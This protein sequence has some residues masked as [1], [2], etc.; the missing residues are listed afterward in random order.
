MS[1]PFVYR[2]SPLTLPDDPADKWSRWKSAP[3]PGQ[4]LPD[5]PLT[6]WQNDRRVESRLRHLTG[7]GFILFT[8]TS[9]DEEARSAAKTS[10]PVINIPFQVIPVLAGYPDLPRGASL[11]LRPDGHLSA[12]RFSSL[13]PAEVARMLS[14][15]LYPPE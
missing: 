13:E 1:V 10:L 11:L 2:D 3:L 8:I 5:Q 15:I 9:D 12:R 6:V 14:L 7:S 4:K